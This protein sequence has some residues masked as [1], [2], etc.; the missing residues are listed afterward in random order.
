MLRIRLRRVGK[1]GRPYYRIVVADSRAPR[2]GAFVDWIGQYDPLMDPP[3]VVLNEE[4]A[5]GWLNK[6]A[7]PSGPVQRIFNWNGIYEKAKAA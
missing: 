5:V 7:Q 3:A 4:K 2:D 6:G 1:K